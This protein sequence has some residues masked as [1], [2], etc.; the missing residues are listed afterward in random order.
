[1][2]AVI[3]AAGRG[4]RLRDVTGD[5]PKCLMRVGDRL[6]IER[7]IRSL[8]GCG[9][10]AITVVAGFRAA[11]VRR[12]C[13]A[14][15]DVVVNAQY[16]STNSLY[17]LWTARDLLLDGFVVLNC[18]VLFHDQ[19][20]RD[21]LSSR[22]DDA[23]LV[24]S[25]RDQHYADEEMKVCVRRGCVV[26]IGKTIDPAEADGENVG[27]AKFGAAGAR[28]LL[29]EATALVGAG[30]IREWLPRAFAAFARRR[31]LHVV[32]TRGYPWIEIDFPEDYWRAC[33]VI[34][35]AIAEFDSTG[36]RRRATFVPAP[37]T[38]SG[39]TLRHV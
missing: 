7:Q 36:E 5:R 4:G 34:L 29:E 23:L 21:L 19:M 16:A 22:D 31:P 39:R 33:A 14:G 8:R 28:V 17:S 13:G 38:A 30:A 24:A 10:D 26:D 9:V 20:L 25:P 2:R 12:S 6:L 3:L 15:V 18:D 37:A 27:I 35:P 11:D 1:M 32:E